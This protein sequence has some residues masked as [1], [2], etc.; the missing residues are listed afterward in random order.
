MVV[1]RLHWGLLVGV[2]LVGGSCSSWAGPAPLP[3]SGQTTKYADGDDGDLQR[4]IPL[5]R[6]RFWSLRNGTVRDSLTGLTWLANA[7]CFFTRTWADALAS[8]AGLADGRC[9]LKDGSS[10][11]EWRLPSVNELESLVDSERSFPSL[12]EGHPFIG[13]RS[14][15]YWSSTTN[16]ARDS[17]AW[18]VD[19]YYGNVIYDKKTKNNYFWPVKDGQ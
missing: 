3:A 11:G 14:S 8:T 1:K 19:L 9:G 17:V 18:V 12:P 13:V 10:A 6:P 16:A 7:N 5:P 15:Y 2:L 4:G